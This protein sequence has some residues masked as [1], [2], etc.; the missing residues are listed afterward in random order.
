MSYTLPTLPYADHA[1]DPVITANTLSF[2]YGKH[3]QGYVTKYNAAIENTPFAD[4][5]LEDVIKQTAG[6][7]N[8]K[9]VFNNG[10]QIFN[11]TFYWNSMTP[12]GGGK[13]TGKVLDLINDTWGDFDTFKTAFSDKAAT[14]FGSGWTWLVKDG[15]KL[16]IVQTKDADTPITTGQTPLLTIDVWEHAYYLDYQNR[17]PDYINAFMDKLVN[18][19]FANQNL[20]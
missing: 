9:A 13:A 3:H 12:N 6:D 20:G 19:D 5:P 18:W 17:R 2:H 8:Q 15:A 10:A 4:T 7:A 14:L 1:L 11:H 16:A